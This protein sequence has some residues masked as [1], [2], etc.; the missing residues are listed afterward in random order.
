MKALKTLN[1]K[2]KE[3]FTLCECMNY[4]DAEIQR[5]WNALKSAKN[6][7]NAEM[8]MVAIRVAH[9]SIND[10]KWFNAMISEFLNNLEW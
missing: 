9:T 5:A 8:R 2:N 6:Q 7:R 10:I 1:N 3:G 4:R